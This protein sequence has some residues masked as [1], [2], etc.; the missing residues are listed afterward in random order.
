MPSADDIRTTITNYIQ[1]FGADREGW[2]D[3]FA[4]NA[5]IEDPVGADPHAGR[6][7]I[8]AFWD[9]AHSL[10]E[11]VE[12]DL[13]GPVCVAGDEAAFAMRIVSTIGD[14]R[15]AIPAID[16]MTFDDDARIATMRAYWSMDAMAP[17]EP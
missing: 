3:L 2:L 1:R 13:T 9:F 8:G 6:E 7:A 14:A 16:A 11:S 5:T 12:L 10:A 4:D 15:M 17:Y